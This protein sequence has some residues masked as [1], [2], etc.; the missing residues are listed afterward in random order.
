MDECVF[1]KIILGEIPSFKVYEDDDFLGFL[2]INPLSLGNSLMVPKKHYRW[3]YDVPNFGEYWEAVK[4]VSLAT[5]KV[6]KDCDSIGYLT[7][8][9]EVAHSHIRIVP[10][11]LGDDH[12]DGIQISKA[13]KYSKEEMRKIA[14]KIREEVER[15]Q[16]KK[17]EGR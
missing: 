13:K 12:V 7:L 15:M 2:D 11:F 16:K 5:K 9:Y 8:G 17:R 3:V 14:G 6:L 1:C 4:I 10:R